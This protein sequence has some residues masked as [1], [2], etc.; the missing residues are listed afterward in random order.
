MPSLGIYSSE[1]FPRAS[2]LEVYLF[3]SSESWVV[4]KHVSGQPGLMP[5]YFTKRLVG[6]FDLA[7]VRSLIVFFIPPP[8][9]FLL[10]V[11]L[12]NRI[13]LC[14]STR[15]H[16]FTHMRWELW[17]ADVFLRF[18]MDH[19]FHIKRANTFSAEK[20]FNGLKFPDQTLPLGSKQ[21]QPDFM[22]VHP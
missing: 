13:K 3:N 4:F 15:S 18:P 21:I 2:R 10:A 11:T 20:P 1:N 6:L 12:S 17:M 8:F 19:V 9:F 5:V 14:P 16:S 7:H 22:L